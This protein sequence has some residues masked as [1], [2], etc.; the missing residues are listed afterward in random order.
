MPNMR[1]YLEKIITN[2]RWEHTITFLIVANAI[3][4]GMETSN[5]I[6]ASAGNIIKWLDTV[7][8]KIFVFELLIRIY[9][10]R[11]QF[12]K[13]PWSIFDTFV[14]MISLVPTTGNLS[15]MRA[16]RVLRVLRLISAVK[17]VKNVVNGLLRALPGMGSITLLLILVFYVFAV[18][19]TMM[20]R[21]EF[22]REFGTIG[23]SAYTLFQIMTLDSWSAIVRPIMDVYPMAWAFFIT[24][25][26]VTSFTVLNL[27]IGIIVEA[28][29]NQGSERTKKVEKTIHDNNDEILK[30][31]K[32]LREEIK[33]LKTQKAI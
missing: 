11:I 16:F 23:I 27:F 7:L 14:V 9:V 4:L 33:E 6:M 12:F 13:D 30:E 22:E 17:S 10:H 5:E 31:L 26:L 24:F 28:M 19:A 1:S 20:F 15:I 18:M 2:K 29:Q 25:I 3:I 8:L 21:V 32:K